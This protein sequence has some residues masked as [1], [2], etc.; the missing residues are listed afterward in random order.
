MH[1]CTCGVK[2]PGHTHWHISHKYSRFR[3][4]GLGAPPGGGGVRC[5][6]DAAVDGRHR[7]ARDADAA[8]GG[9]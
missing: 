9:Q 2:G 7:T 3:V 8:R 4:V 1:V 5:R 6:C